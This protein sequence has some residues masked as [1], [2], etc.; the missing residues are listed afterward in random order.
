MAMDSDPAWKKMRK[1]G[2][3][4]FRDLGDLRDVQ[5][6]QEWV[7]R[8]DSPGDP[9]A[10]RLLQFL[11]NRESQLKQESAEALRAFDRKKW[12]H[13]SRWLPR[14]AARLRQ[15][16]VVF[17][18]LAIERWT[19]GY[20]LHHRALRNRTQV[21]FHRLRIGVKRFRY[22]VENFLPQQHTAWSGDLK[23]LQ[24]LLGEVH[25]LDVLWTTALQMN[26]FPDEE[27]RSR[28]HAR[29]AEERLRRIEKYRK[30]MVGK[31]SL[32]RIWRA[33]LPHGAEIE[34]A[35]LQRLRLWASLQDPN[36]K[37]STHVARLAL[38]LY[39][40][41]AK[42]GRVAAA[43][44]RGQR[45]ILQ[46][47]AL[48]HGVGRSKD[49]KS[50]H[51][52]TYRL[53]RRLTPP[54]GLT[55]TDLHLAGVVARYHRGALP[56]ARQKTLKGLSPSQR[57]NALRL[58]GILRL[59]EGFDAAHDGRIH[60]LDVD[61][62]NGCLVITADGYSPSDRLAERIAAARHL[63]ETVYRRPV[64]VKALRAPRPKL[65]AAS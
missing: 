53:I 13:W 44:V 4:L 55:S 21:A 35:G 27:A 34:S 20:E 15:G 3:R 6:M 26:A 12:S 16:S 28:W 22:I 23:E 11:A 41:L 59:A 17:K 8:L 43:S 64:I 32:W 14:R 46:L 37:H 33:E 61:H 56:Q 40:A 18:H 25:D 62:Q 30:K 51:K 50:H 5:V 9:V 54:L 45:S 19:E 52:T 36:F 7:H 57:Q 39:D 49:G 47:A 48:L 58:A 1:A 42:N 63:L 38:Q 29:I 65:K 60:C 24:D 2:K 10:G 31:A